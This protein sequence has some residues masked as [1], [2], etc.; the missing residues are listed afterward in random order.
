[1][2]FAPAPA[3]ANLV[4]SVSSLELNYLLEQD[5]LGEVLPG[6]ESGDH[7]LVTRIFGHVGHEHG[8]LNRVDQLLDSHRGHELVPLPLVEILVHLHIEGRDGV[9]G[10]KA[11]WVDARHDAAGHPRSSAVSTAVHVAND[12]PSLDTTLCVG[13]HVLDP[14]SNMSDDHSIED[15]G[16]HLVLLLPDLDDHA[17]VV[18]GKT[19]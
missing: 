11:S 8:E 7:R 2:T 17:V 4:D 9:G 19:H 12:P 16:G 15:A 13:D 10:P 5:L 6:G 3:L 14:F 1:M 18:V